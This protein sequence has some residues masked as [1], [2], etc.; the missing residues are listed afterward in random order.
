MTPQVICQIWH[1]FVALTSTSGYQWSS[2]LGLGRGKSSLGQFSVVAHPFS[3]PFP[4]FIVAL[5]WL[6]FC[7]ILSVQQAT[8]G[9]RDAIDV[10]GR[11]TAPGLEK[12]TNIE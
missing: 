4:F 12:M 6:M 8:V 11:N 9:K 2:S 7:D 1:S 10:S 5:S 3:V